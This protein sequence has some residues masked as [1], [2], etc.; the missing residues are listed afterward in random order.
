MAEEA[1]LAGLSRTMS[2]HMEKISNSTVSFREAAA[3]HN[4]NISN[5][6]KDVFTAIAGQRRDLSETNDALE[7]SFS[8]IKQGFRDNARATDALG[9]SMNQVLSVQY[10]TLG[11]LSLLNRNM[12]SLIYNTSG[13]VLGGIF[14][15]IFGDTWFGRLAT[16]LK[17]VLPLGVALGAATMAGQTG[18]GAEALGPGVGQSGSSS[19]A[20]NFFQSKG[21][22]KEQ[23]AGIVGNLQAE[24]GKNLRTNAVGDNGTAYGIAQWHPDRQAKFQQVMGIPIRQSNFQQQ[25]QF[26]DWELKNTEAKA[27]NILRSAQSAEQA[28]SLLD[29]YYERSSGAHRSERMANARALVNQKGAMSSTTTPAAGITTPTTPPTS[30]TNYNTTN[31][32]NTEN[33]DPGRQALPPGTPAAIGPM[34]GYKREEENREHPT[35]AGAVGVSLPK[36]D[37]VALGNALQQQGLRISEHPQFGGVSHVHKGRAHYEGRAIDINVGTGVIE[38]SDPAIA[39]RFDKLADQLTA[40]GYK[41]YWRESGK[42]GAAGH[43]NH[44]HAEILPGGKTPDASP[45]ATTPAGQVTPTTPVT[46]GLTP[47]AQGEA[48]ETPSITNFQQYA[49]E[50]LMQEANLVSGMGIPGM[51]GGMGSIGGIMGMLGPMIGSLGSEGMMQPTTEQMAAQ[52]QPNPEITNILQAAAIEDRVMQSMQYKP[53][54]IEQRETEASQFMQSPDRHYPAGSYSEYNTDNHIYPEWASIVYD[55]YGRFTGGKSGNIKTSLA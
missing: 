31:I 47:Q 52:I 7:E 14:N 37:I 44:L 5:V 39:S 42:Y 43:N 34:G 41:V 20:M 16:T 33:P 27:G 11:E 13:G 21:W 38:A 23:A 8:G 1:A 54:E 45:T 15:N 18:P 24:S 28:A 6:V 30:T 19:E 40:A 46:P 4:K 51:M 29:Q 10:K 49:Q 32:T 50:Q 3:Q 25:L 26:V 2:M 55:I 35:Q 48:R 17:D 22:S 53:P 36:S 12:N 9:E